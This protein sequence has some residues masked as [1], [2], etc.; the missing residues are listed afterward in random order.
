VGFLLF[1]VGSLPFLTIELLN[2]S[3]YPHIIRFD[4][5]DSH[6]FPAEA[7][8]TTDAVNVK[9]TRVL[10]EK[11]RKHHTGRHRGQKSNA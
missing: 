9:L 11:R 7:T 1:L 4:K 2:I 6:T 10:L 3:Q 8:R 5:I